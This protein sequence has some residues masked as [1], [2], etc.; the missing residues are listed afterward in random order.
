MEIR[1][2]RCQKRNSFVCHS[3]VKTTAHM[4]D[5]NHGIQIKVRRFISSHEV[6]RSSLAGHVIEKPLIS[7]HKHER[8]LQFTKHNKFHSREFNRSF[9]YQ[10]LTRY[11]KLHSKHDKWHTAWSLFAAETSCLQ[12]V[13]ANYSSKVYH[14]CVCIPLTLKI[15]PSHL[16][17]TLQNVG[18]EVAET[19]T[20][21]MQSVSRSQWK[22]RIW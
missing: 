22:H 18:D 11:I 3:T 19:R 17:L 5:G 6:H 10:N 12:S 1:P 4:R 20:K 15:G 21:L 13:E 8:S 16:C 9:Q 7:R 2:R 14:L